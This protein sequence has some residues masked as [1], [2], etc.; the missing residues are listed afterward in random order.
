MGATWETVAFILH[1]LGAHNQQNVTL[2]TAWQI[3]FLL[4]PLWINAFVYMTFAR[5]VH[6]FMPDR[7]VSF[8]K[9]SHVSKLF[10]WADIFSFIVQA[11]GGVMTS[12]GVSVATQKIGLHVYEGGIGLQEAFILVF[13]ALMI[14][15][16]RRVLRLDQEQLMIPDEMVNLNET[17]RNDHSKTPTSRDSLVLLYALYAVLAF[18]TVRVP[19]PLWPEELSR[20]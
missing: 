11:A 5:M 17:S 7:K 3:L 10:V 12:P 13:L 20:G 19:L 1:T 9:A 15:F 18:I 2:A 16:H 8:V 6:I 4:A 14:A